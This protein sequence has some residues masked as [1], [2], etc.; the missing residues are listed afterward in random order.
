MAHAVAQLKDLDAPFAVRGGGWMP[1]PGAA[2]IDSSGILLAT[3]NL[4]GLQLSS[5]L[6]TVSVASGHNWA[7]VLDY[8]S[9]HDLVVVGS[10][11]GVVGVPGFLLG[12]GM[13][14][15]SNQYGWASANVVGYEV[16]MFRVPTHSQDVLTS[17]TGGPGMRINRLRNGRQ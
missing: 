8:L 9:P 3:T 7:E 17:M 11:I 5:D 4:T 16:W 13:S 15:L 2:N 10:R 12:G 1:V 6:S 14:F